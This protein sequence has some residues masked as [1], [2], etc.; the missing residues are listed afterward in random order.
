MLL[1]SLYILTLLPEDNNYAALPGKS[2]MEPIH[3][4]NLVMEDAREN[5]K[6]LWILFQ[7]MSKAYDRVNRNL[8]YKA[9]ERI[10]VPDEFIVLLRNSLEN[11]KNKILTNL[12]DT[13]EYIMK[14]GID[15]GET[16]SPLLWI[17][18]YNPFSNK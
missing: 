5:N 2:T 14:N 9:L 13:R 8:L 16:I 7:D 11:R 6:E 18:Y 15:Q 1:T 4:L 12:E 17:I 3:T 10:R